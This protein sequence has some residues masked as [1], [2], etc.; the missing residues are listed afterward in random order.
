MIA[1]Q[2]KLWVEPKKAGFYVVNTRRRLVHVAPLKP[3]CHGEAMK[4]R[5]PRW[6]VPDGYRL[7][8][9]CQGK[10]EA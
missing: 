10:E 7:C 8:L 2:L 9:W 3:R 4:H 1:K 6:F 5:K